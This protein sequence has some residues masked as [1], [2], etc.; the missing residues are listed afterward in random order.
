MYQ[1]KGNAGGQGWRCSPPSGIWRDPPEQISLVTH[2][3]IVWKNPTSTSLRNLSKFSLTVNMLNP[4]S[5]PRLKS[6]DYIKQWIASIGCM[7]HRANTI[8][9][10]NIKHQ[11][12]I[13][14]PDKCKFVVERHI[15]KRNVSGD[16]VQ[17]WLAGQKILRKADDEPKVHIPRNR[18]DQVSNEIPIY[19]HTESKIPITASQM[20]NTPTKNQIQWPK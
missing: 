4:M 18:W 11:N 2:N 13:G 12:T 16:K 9:S 6:F 20:S 1:P 17:Q 7:R 19:S 5:D 8:E 10:M 3:Y 14:R 15:H